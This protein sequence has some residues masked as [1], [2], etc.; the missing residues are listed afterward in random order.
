MSADGCVQS[1]SEREVKYVLRSEV[2][3]N[4]QLIDLHKVVFSKA[5][6]EHAGTPDRNGQNLY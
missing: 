4:A 1:M 5:T 2:K 6:C 3:K